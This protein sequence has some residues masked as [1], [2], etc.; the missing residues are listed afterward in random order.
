VRLY[1][2]TDREGVVYGRWRTTEA[3]ARAWAHRFV[4]GWTLLVDSS[5]RIIEGSAGLRKPPKSG[6]RPTA[7][8]TSHA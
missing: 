3:N 7:E 6:L 2:C 1:T 4:L 8:A 5:G